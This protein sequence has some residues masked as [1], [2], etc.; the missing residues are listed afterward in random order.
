MQPNHAWRL[1]V[2]VMMFPVVLFVLVKFITIRRVVAIVLFR[3]T[4]WDMMPIHAVRG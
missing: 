1:I 3:E 4:R 2:V